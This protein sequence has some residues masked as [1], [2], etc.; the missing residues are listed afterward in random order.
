MTEE[1]GSRRVVIVG[2]GFAGLFA[3]R[4]LSRAPVQV[5]LLDRAEHHLFQPM[6]YQCAT[7][8]LSEGKIAMPL[9]E[10]LRKH[11][12]VEFVLA[13]VTGV[14]PAG[15]R[16]QARRPLGE[17]VEFGYD[18]LILAAGVRQ[19]Y[20][21]HDEYAA[22]AP[23]MKTIE[24]ARRI[25]RR[26][27]GAFELAESADDPAERARWLT[28]ALVGAG[29]TG[30]ELAGQ[31]RE[32]A[33][34]TL[35]R[36]YRRIKPED[37]RVLLFDGGNAPLAMFGQKLS[38]KAA[39]QLG[40]LGVEMHMG[41]IVTHVDPRGLEVKDHGGKV[42]RYEA[43][44]VLWTAGVAAPPLATAVA[45]AAGAEQ[46]RA[47]RLLC[48]PDLSLPGHPDI[49]VTG[50]MMSL[51]KLP[52]VAEVAMQTGLYAGRRISR[53]ALGQA[54]DKPFKYH[55][56]GSAAYI[57]RGHAVVS[58]FN[59][60]FA[61]F[62]GWVVWLFIHIGFLT[63]YRNRVGAIMGWWYAFTRDLR[64]ERTFTIDDTPAWA[65]V[66]RGGL[67]ASAGPA[68]GSAATPRDV[69][70]QAAPGAGSRPAAEHVTRPQ[71]G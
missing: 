13:E 4:A 50:D 69:P 55:D 49:L 8:I 64:R 28:F 32:L 38:D 26:V 63:G 45:K 33:T 60:N 30:V 59:M 67:A 21:G 62:P 25:R 15:R 14:D 42:T 23:G 7:G 29:P 34:K 3:A 56:L 6:L 41:S 58:A 1:S 24:D 10:L 65:G 9:R 43:G 40:K 2:G 20:F 48:G 68:A 37:A 70:R 17:P 11:R 44:T 61:G 51:D 71:P 36:E 66:Y 27:F 18:Y 22:I 31:I 52:G 46:D 19:S 35:R 12:N 57:S 5:T 16:V 39:R 54:Y 47:G 53:E